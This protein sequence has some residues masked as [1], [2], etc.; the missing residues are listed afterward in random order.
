MSLGLGRAARRRQRRLRLLKWS[1]IASVLLA[2]GVFSYISGSTL[3]KQEVANLRS[4]LDRLRKTLEAGRSESARLRVEKDQALAREA[5]WRQ[6]YETE[7]PTGT[8]KQL[9]AEIRAQLKKGV[10]DRRLAYMISAAGNTQTCSGQPVTKRF[11]VRTPIYGGSNDAVN[12]SFSDNAL[13]VTAEGES[14]T[15]STGNPEAW[16]DTAKD[17]TVWFTEIGGKGRSRTSG[18]LPLHHSVIAR[19]VEYRFSV[20]PGERRGFVKVTADRC[21]LS[22]ETTDASLEIRPATPPKPPE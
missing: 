15:N 21:P 3:A 8:T 12:F 22:G 5:E 14:A 13:T 7:V 18:R 19:N 10:A 20:V 11:L 4:E 17:V 9:L 2:L 1:S 16:F 6:R